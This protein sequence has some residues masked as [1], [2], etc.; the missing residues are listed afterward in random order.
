MSNKTQLQV[1]NNTLDEYIA[2][3][4]IAKET[5]AN[6]PSAGGGSGGGSVETCTGTVKLSNLSSNTCVVCFTNGNIQ[7]ETATLGMK[8]A[9]TISPIK[10]SII[11]VYGSATTAIFS[12]VTKLNSF[13]YCYCF[14]IDQ[15]GFSI[16]V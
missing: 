13:S 9:T 14:S 5:A 6:L 8:M 16:E 15:D 7:A 4:N 11:Y 2:R 1:N 3:I 12:G 10:N